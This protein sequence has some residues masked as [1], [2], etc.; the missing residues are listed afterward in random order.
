MALPFCIRENQ[1]AYLDTRSR[2]YACWLVWMSKGRVGR[3]YLFTSDLNANFRDSI[4]TLSGNIG[5]RVELLEDEY[6]VFPLLAH[7]IKTLL[8]VVL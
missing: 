3:N 2:L 5:L 7:V 1:R 6:I 4:Q 8:R